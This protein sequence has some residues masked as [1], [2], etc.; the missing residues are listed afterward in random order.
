MRSWRRTEK[1]I[2]VDRVKNEVLQ[3]VKEERNNIQT[4]T[5]KKAKWIGH[6]LRRNCLLKHVIEGEIEGKLEVKVPTMKT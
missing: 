4:I 3:R 2:W 6:I 5:R 1:I